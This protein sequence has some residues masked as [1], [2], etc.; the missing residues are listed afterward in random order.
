MA[1]RALPRRGSERTTPTGDHLG[2]L[3]VAAGPDAGR[4]GAALLGRQGAA[5]PPGRCRAASGWAGG[6]PRG[7]RRTTPTG[8]HLGELLGRQVLGHRGAAGGH[9]GGELL[10]RLGVGRGTASGIEAHDADRR[11]PRGAAGP[12]G[13]RA[14]GRCRRPPRRGAAGPP[15]GGQGDRLG[16]RGA[17]RRPAI[18]SGSCWAA[19]ALLGRQGAAG[20]SRG[21]QGDRRGDRGA[22][23]R[24]AITSGSCRRKR[25]PPGPR[26]PPVRMRTASAGCCRRGRRPPGRCWTAAGRAGR[27]QRGSRRTTPTG[28]ALQPRGTATRKRRPRGSRRTTPTGDHL[29]ELP[30]QAMATRSSGAAG[31]D[32]DR[33]GGVLPPRATATRAL[34]DRRGAGRETAAGR[35]GRPQRGSRRTTPTGGA[36]PGRAGG[37][38]RTTSTAGR[39]RRGDG[40]QE[41]AA[42]GIEAHDADRRSPRGAAAAGDGH[43]GTAATRS[44]VAAGPDADRHGGALQPQATATRTLLDRRGDRGA[45]RRPAG[46]CRAGQ[47]DRGARRR[48]AGRYSRGERPPG[49]CWAVSGW[50][51]GLQR[52]SRRTTPTGGALQPR[53]MATRA[54]QPRAMATRALLD[55]RGAGRETA[56]GI[57]AHDADRRGAA[58]AGIEA[59]AAGKLL[60]RRGTGQADRGAR[61]RRRGAAA[62]GDGHQG[63]A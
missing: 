53:A 33:L 57:E 58:A 2:E 19:R 61:R 22:R 39:C 32:A 43:R 41:A 5:G 25:W 14:P 35:A 23:R 26:E 45:R 44:S 1:T 31:P 46:S 49:R 34:L 16:D 11:S 56:A 30:P 55:R 4:L 37:S 29:G 40:R 21:G 47:A 24:P 36:L 50:A 48:P 54:L 9:L 42:A 3:P 8:D 59:H 27:P 52:G 15:R 20:P 60:D 7:S 28:G 13:P 12:P 6:P 62:A 38:R 51:G 18:T 10:G 63:A 17:R